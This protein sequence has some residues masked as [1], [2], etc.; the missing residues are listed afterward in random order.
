MTHA[1]ALVLVL[2]LL[3]G[4]SGLKVDGACTYVREI[5]TTYQ[6][7]IEGKLQ[8]FRLAPGVPEP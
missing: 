8:H 3:A 6:C 7:P 5:R 4:C 1:A 2:V